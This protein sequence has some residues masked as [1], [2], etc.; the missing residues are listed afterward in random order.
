MLTQFVRFAG[1]NLRCPGWPCDTPYAVKPKLYREEQVEITPRNLS[2]RI[3]KEAHSTGARNVCI[4]GGEPLLQN[5]D[6]LED[7]LSL[8]RLAIPVLGFEVF[9]NGTRP[10]FGL[11]ATF[12]MDWKLPSSQ[13]DPY[14]KTRIANIDSIDMFGNAIKFVVSDLRDLEVA[15]LLWIQYLKETIIEIYV[16][17]VW[18]KNFE[19]QILEFV[20]GYHLPWRLNVQVHNYVYGAQ[21]RGI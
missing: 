8:C 15:R 17:S 14:H 20:K 1:C 16:G 21:K 7:L 18:G 19:P 11:D 5:H 4:T 10:I 6:D 12:V 13:E 2:E 3:I 9:T